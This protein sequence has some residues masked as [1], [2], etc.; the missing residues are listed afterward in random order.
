MYKRQ[1][2]V[3]AFAERHGHAVVADIKAG[4]N[5]V[6]Q[7]GRF[8]VSDEHQRDD[9]LL[10]LEA[11]VDFFEKICVRKAGFKLQ[12]LAAERRFHTARKVCGEDERVFVICFCE[13]SGRCV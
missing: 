5:T 12:L 8:C 4:H 7:L 11:F 9:G 6:L 2:R 13:E 1:V 3:H 10:F